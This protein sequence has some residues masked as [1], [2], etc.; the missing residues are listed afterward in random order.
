MRTGVGRN[1]SKEGFA[2]YGAGAGAAAAVGGGEGLVQVEVHDVDAE[3]AGAA[4]PTR[5]FMLA[6]SM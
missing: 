5:A 4:L 3:V 2:G 1:G 6:P